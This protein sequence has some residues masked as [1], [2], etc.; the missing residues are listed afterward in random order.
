[1]SEPKTFFINRL[2]AFYEVLKKTKGKKEFE[3][4]IRT[5]LEKSFNDDID[6]KVKR[7]LEIPGA[8]YIPADTEYFK[9]YSELMQ[10]YTNGMYYST[11][12]LSGVLCERICYD[13]LLKSKI[14]INGKPL[15]PEQISCLFEMN[16]SYL[17]P[18]LSNWGL[19]NQKSEKLMWKINQK[20]NEYVHP[21]KGKTN[22]QNDALE[23]IKKVTDILMNELRLMV[24]PKG[25][26]VFPFKNMS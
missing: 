24:E 14:N 4:M 5:F 16:L 26:A 23:I 11:V 9:L 21:K 13:I 3:D 17:L 22:M 18:L 20:R 1:M 19:I 12:V 7:F 8:D 6:F 15:S 25:S 10:L 2:P